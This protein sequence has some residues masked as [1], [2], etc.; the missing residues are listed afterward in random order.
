MNSNSTRIHSHLL[1]HK[2][3]V[4]NVQ[5]W[6]IFTYAS[7]ADQQI[8]I[9]SWEFLWVAWFWSRLPYVP[10][11][12]MT[13][14]ILGHY[15]QFSFPSNSHWISMWLQLVPPHFF[16]FLQFRHQRNIFGL[17][18]MFGEYLLFHLEEDGGWEGGL[19]FW[20]GTIT[21]LMIFLDLFHLFLDC[22]WL[23]LLHW[24]ASCYLEGR[25]RCHGG[26]S[27]R[28]ENATNTSFTTSTTSAVR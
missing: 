7:C 5:Y 26:S 6:L 9:C 25:W 18:W 1:G 21:P 3:I 24:D 20:N 2:F 16:F 15:I 23:R 13:S 19:Y 12:D 10:P 4:L 17:P 27:R 28:A 14:D 8:Q 22:I 11:V